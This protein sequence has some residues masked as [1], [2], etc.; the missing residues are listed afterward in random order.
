MLH[1]PHTTFNRARLWCVSLGL[2]HMDPV[3]SVLL[4]EFT[5][6]MSLGT[7]HDHHY[8]DFLFIGKARVQPYQL[9]NICD[10]VLPCLDLILEYTISVNNIMGKRQY[11]MCPSF[12]LVLLCVTWVDQG[13]HHAYVWPFQ[14]LCPSSCSK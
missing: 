9:Q 6:Y 7:N 2:L 14:A 3:F 4:V 1:L 13:S 10:V 12:V 11:L 5:L 8:I